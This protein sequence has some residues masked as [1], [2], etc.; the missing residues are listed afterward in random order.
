MRIRMTTVRALIV[1]A[2]IHAF[3]VPLHAA[4]V[5]VESGRSFLRVLR[6]GAEWPGVIILALSLA[7]VTIIIEHF[8]TIRRST[9]SPQHEIENTRQHI[10]ARRFK[11]AI[12]AIQGSRTMFAD[13]MSTALRHGRH[14]FDAM[15]E[16]A[17]ERGAAW[18]SR[19]FRKVDALNVIGNLAP[20]MGLLGTVLGMIEAFGE[21][22][23]AH[24]AYKPEN[25]A[26][27]ISLAL[28]NTFLGL[29]VAI[30]ALGF[31]GVCR[32]R[33]DA[34]TVAAHAA[35]IDLLEFFR[36][37]AVGMP[38][39]PP[40]PTSAAAAPSHAAVP[41]PQTAKQEARQSGLASK[42]PDASAQSS[43]PSVPQ[44]TATSR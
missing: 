4:D 16:A 8:W 31:F 28:V 14:G 26:G 42:S 15:H 24:G 22:Q 2:V 29:A 9:M 11:E 5:P 32:S 43:G 41:A 39:S 25:L 18:T 3:A 34:M 6:D 21:M 1:I 40:P 44:P 7:A 35:A 13:V 10:E 33:V 38:A 19:L 12:E 17:D 20:L 30:I 23:A 36:P 27:G 37:V